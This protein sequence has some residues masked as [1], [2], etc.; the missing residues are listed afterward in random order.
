MVLCDRDALSPPF[1][2]SHPLVYAFRVQDRVQALDRF[3][4]RELRP[5]VLRLREEHNCI[6]HQLQ[7]TMTKT[8]KHD[9]EGTLTTTTA[10]QKQA[11]R[12]KHQAWLWKRT[13]KRQELN[14]FEPFHELATDLQTISNELNPNILRLTVLW[15]RSQSIAPHKQVSADDSKDVV[16]NRERI[17]ESGDRRRYWEGQ[18]LSREYPK[19]N[20]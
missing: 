19:A 14:R 13:S 18:R 15:Q 10:K 2:F 20:R 9:S 1:A 4:H 12:L 3:V 17:K 6:E 8:K 16:Y 7:R 5:K 11:Q